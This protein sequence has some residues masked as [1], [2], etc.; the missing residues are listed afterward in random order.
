MLEWF[1]SW[2]VCG[3]GVGGW[4][5]D[6]WWFPL[7]V[8][9]WTA[10]QSSRMP[11]RGRRFVPLNEPVSSTANKKRIVFQGLPSKPFLP[12][13]GCRRFHS[14]RIRSGC[15]PGRKIDLAQRQQP[16][17]CHPVLLHLPPSPTMRGIVP[18]A[19]GRKTQTLAAALVLSRLPA[20]QRHWLRR[21]KSVM[22]E[23]RVLGTMG[24]RGRDT[25]TMAEAM[26]E[27]GRGGSV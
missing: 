23:T 20:E 18:S 22:E 11:Q 7:G 12:R 10:P 6:A 3:S 5:R 8:C 21:P 9:S 27:A 1:L 2:I 19:L 4:E 14:T 13:P 26:A 24:I 15:L 17:S 25:K 16:K